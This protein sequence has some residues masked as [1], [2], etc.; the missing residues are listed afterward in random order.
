MKILLN[1]PGSRLTGSHQS[2]ASDDL[3]SEGLP[4]F[5]P[6]D[7]GKYTKVTRSTLNGI[8]RPFV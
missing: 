8:T 2:R 5:Q 6:I 1:V 3:W 7:T 4:V